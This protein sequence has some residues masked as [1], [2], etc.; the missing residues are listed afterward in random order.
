MKG[1]Q[2]DVATLGQVPSAAHADSADTAR[3]AQTAVA[4]DH[5]TDAST[6]NGRSVGCGAEQREFAG[7]CWDMRSS[8]A[9]VTAT[10]AAVACAS[11]GGELPQALAVAAFARQSGVVIVAS[12]EWSSDI[13]TL[14]SK[15]VYTVAY[16]IPGGVI[17]G[18]DPETALHFR[19]VTPLLD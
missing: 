4:A 5:A 17:E 9:A 1:D 14:G 19:C 16:V 18:V 13:G 10:E 11:R 3:R 7:A 6:V 12:G 2:I 15:G 8:A